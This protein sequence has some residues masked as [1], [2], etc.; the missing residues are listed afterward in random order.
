MHVILLQLSRYNERVID[1]H[2]VIIMLSYDERSS[3]STVGTR[4]GQQP[5]CVVRHQGHATNDLVTSLICSSCA[6][7]GCAILA[8]STLA[9]LLVTN[10]YEFH[11]LLQYLNSFLKCEACVPIEGDIKDVTSR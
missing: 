8:I 2:Q 6:T 10:R 4:V 11:I 5:R 1:R 9:D 3:A 7:A